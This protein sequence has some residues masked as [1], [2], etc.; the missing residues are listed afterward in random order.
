MLA[1]TL[2]AILA[3][4]FGDWECVAVDD[5]STD[6]TLQIS[7]EFAATESRNCV[8]HQENQGTA[9]ASTAG[10]SSAVGDFVVRCSADDILL[11]EHLPRVSALIGRE[12]GHDID[13][14]SRYFWRPGEFREL[15]RG[16]GQD[17]TVCSPERSDAVRR[18][19]LGVGAAYRRGPFATVGGYPSRQMTWSATQRVSASEVPTLV[20]RRMDADRLFDDPLLRPS[21]AS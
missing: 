9:G 20:W 14:S 8:V 13:S 15:Y 4:R 1:E 7:A 2:D 16:P 18:R 21:L 3:Q 11:P 6:D 5:G 19:F 17:A 12:D 10:V